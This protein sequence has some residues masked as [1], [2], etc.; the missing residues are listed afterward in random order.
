VVIVEQSI[1]LGGSAS[2]WMT[3]LSEG[4]DYTESSWSIYSIIIVNYFRLLRKI[5]VIHE[6]TN[7]L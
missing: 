6:G 1:E 7:L 4:Q 2:S 3:G 5:K